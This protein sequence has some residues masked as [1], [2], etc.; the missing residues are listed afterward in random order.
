MR[1]YYMSYIK[2][3]TQQTRPN[4]VADKYRQNLNILFCNNYR[5]KEA[6]AVSNADNKNW[7]NFSRLTKLLLIYEFTK[8]KFYQLKWLCLLNFYYSRQQ[9]YTCLISSNFSVAWL[10]KN[11]NHSTITP[12]NTPRVFHVETKWKRSFLERFNQEY[13]WCVSRD[14]NLSKAHWSAIST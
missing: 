13:T 6:L 14:A 7:T 11:K 5:G 3:W 8:W 9:K 2:E 4:T 1:K 12:T 10:G